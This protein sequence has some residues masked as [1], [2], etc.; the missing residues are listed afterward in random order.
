[1]VHMTEAICCCQRTAGKLLMR[2]LRKKRH[3]QHNGHRKQTDRVD[4]FGPNGSTYSPRLVFAKDGRQRRKRGHSLG[5]TGFA[6]V[7]QVRKAVK[8]T[9]HPFIAARK[10]KHSEL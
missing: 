7:E 2:K 4:V 6:L 1:M 8:A 9:A 3:T 10:R 5:E